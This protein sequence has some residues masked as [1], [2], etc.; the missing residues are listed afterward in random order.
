QGGGQ[1]SPYGW[2]PPYGGGY[3]PYGPPYGSPYG[4]P[5]PKKMGTGLK[6]FLWIVGIVTVGL[7][8]AFVLFA[9]QPRA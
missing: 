7:V 1:G 9:A 6:V 2:G 5:P 3:P 4:P 8:S